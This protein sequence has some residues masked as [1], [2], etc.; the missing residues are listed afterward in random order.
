MAINKISD[1]TLYKIKQKSAKMLP[2]RP[3]ASG[4]TPEQ[5]KSYLADFVIGTDVSFKV[6]LDRIVDEINSFIG[7]IGDVTVQ[8]YVI[9]KITEQFKTQNPLLTLSFNKGTNLLEYKKYDGTGTLDIL[10]DKVSFL[11]NDLL[12]NKSGNI[13]YPQTSIDKMIDKID[14]KTVR[15]YLLSLQTKITTLQDE[16]DKDI[17]TISSNLETL[18]G[19]DA[20]EALNTIKELAEA[21]NNNPTEVDDILQRL[22]DLENNKVD[23]VSGKGLSTNDFTNDLKA[24]L[25]AL[26][27]RDLAD[28]S[29][30]STEINSFVNNNKHMFVAEN[31]RTA[32]N[33]KANATHIHNISDISNLQSVLDSKSE[34]THTHT[35]SSLGA[36]ASGTASNLISQHNDNE[37]SHTDIRELIEQVR[38]KI[39]GRYSAITFYNTQQLTDWLNGTY[40]R[41]DNMTPNDL[42]VGQNIYIEVSYEHDYWVSSMPV[43]TIDDLDVLPT[44]KVY[45]EDYVLKENLKNITAGDNIYI[46]MDDKNIIINSL[47]EQGP[48]GERGLQGVQGVQGIQG[49]KGEKGDKGDKGDTGES[50]VIT[51]INGFFTLSVDSDGNLYAYSAEDGT[52]PEFEYDSETGNLYI[53]QEQEE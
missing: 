24:D 27:Q 1:E 23:K 12:K 35:L 14:D 22:S 11:E 13:I 10:P 29:D 44:D 45:L 4:F 7:Q 31:E 9:D 25:E 8:N 34:D 41:N 49:E 39:D 21:L 38:N 52:T 40:T 28:V 30:I 16:H 32:W 20:P 26:L 47:V 33:S 46:S 50:G 51:S 42:F 18:M 2:N 6:E 36:E 17:A 37:Y 5:I 3:S 15:E 19:G 53:V 43:S 48:Q